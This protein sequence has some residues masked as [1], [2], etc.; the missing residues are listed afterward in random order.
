MSKKR[1]YYDISTILAI[2]PKPS[3]FIIYGGR[4]NGKSYQV[5]KTMIEDAYKGLNDDTGKMIYIRRWGKDI[6]QDAVTAYFDDMP[7]LRLTNNQYSGIVAYQGALYFTYLD[8]NDKI[9]RSKPIGRYLALNEAERYKSQAFVGYK[10]AVY[11]EFIT[12]AV[13]LDN[14][15]T[16]LQNLISTIARSEYLRVFMVGNSINR[17]NPFIEDFGLVNILRQKQG[18]IEVYHHQVGE[19][20]IHIAV[21]YCKKEDYENKMFFGNASKVIVSGEWETKDMPR[22]PQKKDK[23]IKAYEIRIDYQLFSFMIEL[24]IEPNKGGKI[25]YVYP[26]TRKS[27]KVLRILTEKMDDNPLH[28]TSLDT[29][30]RPELLIAECFR[31]NK[32]CYS[33]NLTAADFSHVNDVFKFASMY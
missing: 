9:H 30:R 28:T 1:T 4:N 6:K 29:R 13:Y 16:K 21:E 17:V 8:E 20:T 5:K 15:G 2:E 14:E 25:V 23:Y 22:L 24:L 33:D 7:V 19:E 12:D 32:V 3:Y 27:R 11:E 10:N 18:T 26:A 31:Q